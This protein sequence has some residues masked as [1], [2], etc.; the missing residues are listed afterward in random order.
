[1]NLDPKGLEILASEFWFWAADWLLK[2]YGQQIG[3]ASGFWWAVANS[4]RHFKNKL[5]IPAR[6]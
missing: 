4:C 5:H 3:R 1:L 6:L 2:F